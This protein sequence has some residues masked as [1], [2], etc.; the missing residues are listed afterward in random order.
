MSYNIK[1]VEK[2][3]PIF[4]NQPLLY[5]LNSSNGIDWYTKQ[6]PID[7]DTSLTGFKLKIPAGYAVIFGEL[8]NDH[9]TAYNQDFINARV[10]NLKKL[11]ILQNN[12]T[13]IIVPTSFDSYFKKINGNNLFEI[14]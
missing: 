11:D 10:F 6:I 12:N 7:S 2:G 4:T 14:K 5:K 13:I 8:N 3:F 9:Y 1:E